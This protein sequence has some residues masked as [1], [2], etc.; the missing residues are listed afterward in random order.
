MDPVFNKD[1]DPHWA[2]APL[3]SETPEWHE[4]PWPSYKG[5]YDDDY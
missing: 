4:V 2:E 5:K 1:T 3:K